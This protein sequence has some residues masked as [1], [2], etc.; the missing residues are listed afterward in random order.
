MAPP[1][2]KADNS[3]KSQGIKAPRGRPPRIDSRHLLEVAR[4]VFLEQGIR[5]TTLEVAERAGVSEGAV[6]HRFKSKEMLFR[7]AMELEADDVPELFLNAVQDLEGRELQEALLHLGE[8]L[9]QIGRVALPLMM[10]SWSNPEGCAQGSQSPRYYAAFKR[11]AGYFERQMDAGKLRRMDSEVITRA[12]FGSIH[13]YCMTRTLMPE[14]A[15]QFM[16]EG[17]F[18]RGLVDLLFNGAS[19]SPEH[20]PSPTARR[21]RRPSNLSSKH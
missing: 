20:A 17:M 3:L 9:I 4:E 8:T 11:L 16:P 7:A 2:Q 6:F 18:L 15:A 19:P 12:F 10:M 1:R 5:A 14:L 13:H 21:L